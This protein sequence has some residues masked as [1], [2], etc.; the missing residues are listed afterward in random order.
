MEKAQA[1]ADRKAIEIEKKIRADIKIQTDAMQNK[2]EQL[3]ND[4]TA[5]SDEL[6]K[7]IEEKVKNQVEAAN[8]KLQTQLK[9]MQ[10]SMELKR[11]EMQKTLEKLK[12]TAGMQLVA[13]TS[14]ISKNDKDMAERFFLKTC[15]TSSKSSLQLCS[16]VFFVS[17]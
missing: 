2:V 4:L 7:K 10:D 11:N 12:N 17:G 9:T 3:K 13:A 5:Q 8:Q 16:V 6:G 1:D 15:D 14:T